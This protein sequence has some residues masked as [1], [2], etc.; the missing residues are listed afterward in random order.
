[1]P[2]VSQKIPN[3][4]GGVSQ[5]PDSLK[6]PG[7]LRESLN[8][9]PDPTYGLLKRPGLKLVSQL[10]NATTDGRWFSIFRDVNEKYVGQFTATGGLRIWDAKTGVQQTVN[11]ISSSAAAYI[12]GV[13]EANFEMLQISDY[14]FVLNRT[15]V[16][17]KLSTTSPALT[18][19]AWVSV[20]LVGYGVQYSI[21][22]DATTYSYTT[23]TTGTVS[24]D[25][26]LTGLATAIGSSTYTVVSIGT[27]LSIRRNNNA[28][29]TVEAKGG[30]SGAAIT[31]FKG[32]VPTV[33]DL[34]ISCEDGFTFKVANLENAVGDDYYVKFNV[35]GSGTSGAG[36]WEETVAPGSQLYL[37][38]DTMPHV[39]I[40]ESNGT[41]T[42]RSL[43]QAAAGSTTNYWIE[44][45]VGDDTSNP[46]PTFVGNPITGIS[47]FRNRLV[48]FSGESVIC[49]QPGGFFNL[50][51]VSA[52]T[53]TDGDAIDLS[54]GSQKPV[55][56]KYAISTTSGLL[57]FSEFAQFLLSTDADVFGPSTAKI[58]LLSNFNTD[59]SI[60]PV[61]TGTSLVFTDNNQGFCAVTEML[62]T[63]VDNRPQISDISRTTPNFVPADIRSLVASSSTSMLSFLPLTEN[64][65]L[66]LFKFFNNGAN[67]VLA[68]WIN[69]KLPGPCVFQV[70]DHD[71][72]YFVT[73]QQNG[74]CLSTCTV[75]S[76][77]EGTAVNNSGI[78]YEYR[79]DLFTSTPNKTYDSATDTTKV[80]FKPG[81]ADSTLQAI[82]VVDDGSTDKGLVYI[83]NQLTDGV[84]PYVAVPGNRTTSTI[85]LGYAF[86]MRLKLPRFYI[87]QGMSDGSVKADS[88][89]IPRVQRIIIESSDTGPYNASVS[90]LG[91]PSV[92]YELSQVTANNYQANTPP[93]PSLIKNTIPVMGKGTDVELILSSTTPFPLSFISMTWQGTYNNRGIREI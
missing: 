62:V 93:L 72:F 3:L 69:W 31:A 67:R 88:I 54:C 85:T 23:P 8:V 14:N 5:Q 55:D 66:Y 6:L 13:S 46:F 34:P 70:A 82:A 38:P 7:Q 64:N 44:R 22:L 18:P 80:Y 57:L 90:V 53:A 91:R 19:K 2:V 78:S 52:I 20:N 89:N 28:D 92:S 39:I 81:T 29:F 58:N 86:D 37:D 11:T 45:K 12:A 75:L 76:D 30:L 83:L 27:G 36:I 61:E 63:S 32:A 42:F 26:V 9:V 40:R 60:R 68:S 73:Q 15:K 25:A 21:K 17:S 49:S 1:M 56:L 16:V 4:L 87:K 71:K 47:F 65:Y 77:V 74:V 41:F 79:L 33:A 10:A 50:F 43:N 48:L 51:A 35:D 24:V 84:G 59:P